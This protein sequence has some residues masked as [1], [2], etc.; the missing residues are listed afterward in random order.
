MS[1]SSVFGVM[2]GIAGEPGPTSFLVNPTLILS[3][4][5]F[6][7]ILLIILCATFGLVLQIM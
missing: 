1:S 7:L 4:L 6:S 3:D 2:G 5:R